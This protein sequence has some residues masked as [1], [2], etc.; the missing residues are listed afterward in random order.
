MTKLT[1]VANKRGKK[2]KAKML[3]AIVKYNVHAWV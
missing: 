3:E 1:I 2:I